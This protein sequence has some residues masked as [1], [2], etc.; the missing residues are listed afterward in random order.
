MTP[1]KPI[2][3]TRITSF[4]WT[5]GVC[6]LSA[7]LI[8]S[9]P[10][11]AIINADLMALLP[12]AERDPIVHA[13]TA[14]VT[15][16]FERRVA[17]LVGADDFETAKAAAG[18]VAE[19]LIGT[20]QFHSLHTNQHEDLARRAISFYLPLRFY[21]LTDGA[22]AQL[23]DGKAASFER[24]V[25]RQ[26]FNP[27]STV[28]SG[29]IEKDPLL[30]LPRFLQQRAAH[31]ASGP[32]IKDGYVTIRSGGKIY[33]LLLGEL[34]GSPFSLSLQRKLMPLISDMRSRLPDKFPGAAF[35]MAGALPHAAAG[36]KSALDETS[37]VGVGSIIGIIVLL[38]AIFRSVRP[39]VLAVLSIGLGC[40]A[41]FAACILVFGEVHLL[42]FVF[43]ASLVG[44]SVDYSLHYFCERF[45]FA[46]DW[47]PQSALRHIMPGITLGLITSV[48]GFAGLFFAPFPG[49]QGMAVFSSVGL[50][51]AYGTV[52]IC[53]PQYT[54]NLARP[55]IQRPL[56]WMRAYG[57]AWQR[58]FDWRAWS[59]IAI[60]IVLAVMGSLRLTASDDIRLLQTPDAD[61][62]AEE[63]RVQ[64]LMGQSPAS[65]F[66]LVEGRDDADFL[67]RSEALNDQLRTLRENRQLGDI[68]TISDFIPSPRRQAENHLL[69]T[70]LILGVGNGLERVANR[71]GLPEATRDAYVNAFKAAKHAPP[72]T[73]AQWL[74]DPVS[75]PYRHLWLGRTARGVIGVVGLRG[76]IDLNAL[77]EL[78]KGQPKLH[79][80]DPAGEVSDLFREYRRQTIWL[81]LISY[82]AVLLLLLVRYGLI[83]GLLV[84][85]S[86]AIAAIASLGVLGWLGEP[87]N[88]FN[89]MG[90][91]LVLGIGIDYALFFRETGAG[92]PSTLLAIALSSITTLLAFGLLA[93]SVTTAIHSFGLTIL[94]GISVAFLLSPMAGW[95]LR[96]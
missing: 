35:L 26:Y 64:K 25:L 75:E 96:Q 89:V 50:C 14:N 22:R 86:P 90:L 7:W 2:L 73:L 34:A 8:L 46:A 62:M 61:V 41:G 52:V 88:L 15:K 5:A 56:E 44:I 79:F 1:R 20:G 81:T 45:R 43:G 74:T 82:G 38:F 27:Q 24:G 91:L 92:N 17:M 93:L 18:H 60:L 71:V 83:G 63:K 28:S 59:T 39:M 69:L 33:I 84:M 12:T 13:A 94:I 55:G 4:L 72:A 31:A 6:A 68:I 70:P 51:I 32:Q 37:T 29:L 30:L 10:S 78:A 3:R 9:A 16:R 80:I 95:K 54:R 47:S 87:I 23:R 57:M 65:Q 66:F 42:T 67:E 21:L 11:G 53:Y 58:R 19:Q 36:T 85:A 48:I 49:M 76:V 40:L 77:Q